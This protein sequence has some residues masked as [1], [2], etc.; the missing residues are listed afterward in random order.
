MN[1]YVISW[2]TETRNAAFPMQLSDGC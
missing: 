1:D 2:M